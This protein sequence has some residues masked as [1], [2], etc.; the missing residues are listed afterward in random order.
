[1]PTPDVISRYFSSAARRQTD[2]LVAL[3]TA[4]AV[5]IDEGETYR[6]ASEIRKWWED[7]ATAFEYTTDVLGVEPAGGADYVA[8]EHLAGNFP[9]GTVDLRYRFSIANDRIRRLEI[10]P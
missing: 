2:A 9:G 6:G 1:M 4:D 5:V 10:A 3:F 8:R 7:P